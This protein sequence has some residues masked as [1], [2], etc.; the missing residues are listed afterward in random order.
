[1]HTICAHFM[2]D[3]IGSS[4]CGMCWCVSYQVMMHTEHV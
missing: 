3:P 4:P 1:M 2:Y